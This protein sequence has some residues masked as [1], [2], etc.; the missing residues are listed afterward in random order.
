MNKTIAWTSWQYS[1]ELLSLQYLLKK[2]II[3]HIYACNEAA[4]ASGQTRHDE[5][6][7]GIQPNGICVPFET[8]NPHFIIW[9]ALVGHLCST[10]Y[11]CQDILCSF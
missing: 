6:K 10:H 9:L 11:L 3:T 8:K 7:G 2:H 5:S 1:Q 4:T